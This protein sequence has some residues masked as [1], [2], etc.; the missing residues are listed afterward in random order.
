MK[1]VGLKEHKSIAK[2]YGDYQS[3]STYKDVFESVRSGEAENGLVLID[4]SWRGSNY[5]VYD[6]FYKYNDVSVIAEINQE[7]EGSHSRFFVI[8]KKPLSHMDANKSS[9]IFIVSHKPGSLY[10]ALSVFENYELN[11]TK[12]ES[13]R[14][15]GKPSDY[16]FYV[17]FEYSK[18]HQNKIDEI[19]AVY[20]EN[21]QYLRVIGFYKSES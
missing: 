17:D 7:K 4:D 14:M 11:L 9:M 19:I 18:E 13:R 20:K 8:G 15:Y 2:G 3:N 6:L 10:S 5:E 12:I 1:I 16:I 21:T